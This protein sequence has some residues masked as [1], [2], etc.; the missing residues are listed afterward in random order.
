MAVLSCRSLK[1]ILAGAFQLNTMPSKGDLACERKPLGTTTR[2]GQPA[3]LP[4][5]VGGPAPGPLSRVESHGGR[6]FAPH[7]QGAAPNLRS[8][9]W[10]SLLGLGIWRVIQ[11]TWVQI[12]AIQIK[13]V[14]LPVAMRGVS[15]GANSDVSIGCSCGINITAVTLLA[16]VVLPFVSTSCSIL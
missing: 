15:S 7:H 16:S 6:L 2:T 12:K 13:A 3:R 9:N 8:C 10:Q 1:T 4:R 5:T 14:Q 11:K